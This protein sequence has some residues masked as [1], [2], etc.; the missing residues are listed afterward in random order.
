VNDTEV[1]AEGA[2]P[3]FEEALTELELIVRRLD[4][5]D[6]EL[7]QALEL[8]EQ[9]IRRLR[10]AGQMLDTGRGRVEELIEGASGDLRAIGLTEDR[11][12]NGANDD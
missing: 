4:G 9:G 3:S 2:L 10:E 5:P 6:L 7:D 11:A 1:N 12:E 8:F